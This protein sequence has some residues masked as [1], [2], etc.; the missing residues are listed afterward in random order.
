[1]DIVTKNLLSA[2]KTEESL[3]EDIKQ[4]DLLEHFVNFCVAAQE[5][6]EEIDINDMYTGGPNDLGI[7]GLAIVVNGTI[8][9]DAAEVDDLANTNRYLDAIFVFCQAKS[10]AD[11]SGSEISNFFFGV[12]NLFATTVTLPINDALKRKR[13]ILQEI[14]G[15]SSLFKKGN[16]LVKL[17]YATTGKWV[18]DSTLLQRIGQDKSD[19][20]DLNIFCDCEFNPVD[21]RM[22]QNLY[23]KSKNRFTK[24]FD[25]PNRVT[26]PTLPNI[27]ESYM[28]FLRVNEYLKLI[29]DDVGGIARGLFYDNVRDFQGENPVN[30]EIAD[31]L[32]STDRLLLVLLNNGVTIVADAISITADRFTVEDYQIVNGCQTSHVLFN[33]NDILSA[34]R[35]VHIPIKLIV[36]ENAEVKNKIIKATNRQTPVKTEELTALTDFQKSLEDYYNVTTG[37]CKLYYERRSQQFRASNAVEKIRIVS[38]P[39]QIRAFASMFL[40][41]PHQA[42]RYYGTLLKS[43]ETKIFR[44]DHPPVAYYASSLCLFKFESHLRKKLIEVKFRPFKYHIL[45]IIRMQTAGLPMPS[46]TSNKFDKY[47][48]SNVDEMSDDTRT[49]IAFVNATSLLTNILESNYDRDKAKDASIVNNA[50]KILS[51]PN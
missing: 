8:V 51:R 4:S 22:L 18:D 48:Q 17:Y 1:M 20:M 43:I 45:A 27:K 2:F 11:F 49:K 42:S 23:S 46:M 50:E 32:K 40:S 36:S 41:M 5:Y 34:N 28:G 14:Y 6:G 25:F 37:D 19:L 16:P 3:P 21:A 7:D 31:T 13:A 38:V 15:K 30:S 29:T 24:T 12:R 26:L 39:N 33:H 47:C 35:D 10:S 9:N 44:K